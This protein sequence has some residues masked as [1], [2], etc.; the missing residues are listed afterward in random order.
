MLNTPVTTKD[1]LIGISFGVLLTIA[2]EFAFK[3]KSTSITENTKDEVFEL[4][5]E[6]AKLEGENGYYKRFVDSTM[7]VLTTEQKMDLLNKM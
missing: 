5:R 2:S 3:T 6:N 4:Q 1:L 7:N